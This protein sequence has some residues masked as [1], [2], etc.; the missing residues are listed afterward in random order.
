MKRQYPDEYIE[1]VIEEVIENH[2]VLDA[3]VV[4]AI[5][6]EAI[7]I[8]KQAQMQARH[9]EMQTRGFERG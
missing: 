7:S 3:M 8:Y 1:S 5:A 4:R 2:P 9:S 6:L